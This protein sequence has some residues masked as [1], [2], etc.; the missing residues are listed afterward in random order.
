MWFLIIHGIL[1]IWVF[2]DALMRKANI[3]LWVIGTTI[4]GPII[5]PVY[6][7]K[8]PLKAGE[9][10]ES[11]RLLSW[12]KKIAI[13]WT[14]LLVVAGIWS[15]KPVNNALNSE[16]IEYRLAVINKGGYVRKDDVT[17]KRFRT[18]LDQ[19]SENCVEDQQQI[20]N[21]SLIAKDKINSNGM[22]V[23]LLNIMED[24]NKLVYRE[25]KDERYSKYMF[26]YVGLRNNG[27]SHTEAIERLQAIIEGY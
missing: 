2:I 24:L 16:T 23:P 4:L 15:Q 26:A 14:I 25:L 21:I 20:A 10:R 3:V 7:S 5:L 6:V 12:L 11:D 17:V 13:S 9:F 1:A 19:L 22:N 27:L 8:R 18:L